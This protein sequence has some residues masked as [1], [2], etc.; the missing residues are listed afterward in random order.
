MTVGI[1]Y[2]LFVFE[3][4]A[5]SLRLIE[6][7]DRVLYHLEAIDIENDEY[8][9]WDSTGGGVNVTVVQK[10]V[11]V[12]PCAAVLPLRDALAAYASANGLRELNVADAPIE[13]WR[14]I[15]KEIDARPKKRSF[16]ERL[17]R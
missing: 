1:T 4:D 7:Q 5:K 10:K 8:V 2:P 17:F 3:K 11:N 6:D 16:L 9:F 14:R 15:Q 13:V 12:N